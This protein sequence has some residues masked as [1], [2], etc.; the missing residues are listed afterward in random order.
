MNWKENPF[1]KPCPVCENQPV[2]YGCAPCDDYGMVLDESKFLFTK[3]TQEQHDRSEQTVKTV[4]APDQ[5]WLGM[6][7]DMD[8]SRST[9]YQILVHEKRTVYNVDQVTQLLGFLGHKPRPSCI[10]EHDCCGCVS[11]DIRLMSHNGRYWLFREDF[12]RNI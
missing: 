7:Y 1:L 2:E 6:Q 11:S 8:C 9:I 4:K 10:C 3:W 12:S 5:Q